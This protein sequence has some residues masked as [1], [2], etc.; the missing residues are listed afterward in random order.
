LVIVDDQISAL[1]DCPAEAL[2]SALNAINRL[3]QAVL[4]QQNTLKK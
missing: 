3:A 4:R 2:A 1:P